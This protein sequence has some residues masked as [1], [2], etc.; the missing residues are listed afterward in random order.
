MVWLRSPVHML[1]VQVCKNGV[2]RLADMT[3]TAPPASVQ[4]H[5]NENY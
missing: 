5:Y 2:A 4:L 3:D 1:L